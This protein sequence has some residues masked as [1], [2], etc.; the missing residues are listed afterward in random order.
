MNKAES[1]LFFP[2]HILVMKRKTK[3]GGKYLVQFTSVHIKDFSLIFIPSFLHVF[4][5]F[6]FHFE[7]LYKRQ[8]SILLCY[9]ENRNKN[10]TKPK[11]TSENSKSNI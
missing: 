7:G 5:R 1:K 2:L 9:A 6:T 8:M 11:S 10:E 3:V 4:S